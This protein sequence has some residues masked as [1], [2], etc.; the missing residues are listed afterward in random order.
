MLII[1]EDGFA[2]RR[3]LAML[4]LL[5]LP[6]FLFAQWE[7]LPLYG[8]HADRLVQNKFKPNEIYAIIE[9]GGIYRSTDYGETWKMVVTNIDTLGWL[10]P[11]RGIAEFEVSADNI[12]FVNAQRKIWKSTDSGS[13]WSF[14]P[15]LTQGI[16][17]YYTDIEALPDTSILLLHASQRYIIK[18]HTK[19]STYDTLPLTWPT[20]NYV[21]RIFIDPSNTHCIILY[22]INGELVR[23]EDDGKHFKKS[24]FSDNDNQI[25]G[26]Q[27]LGLNSPS[28]YGLWTNHIADTGREYNYFESL[29]SGYS[30]RRRNEIPV[31][32]PKFG[33]PP[34]DRS[35]NDG[36][37]RILMSSENYLTYSDDHGFSFVT[38]ND[39]SVWD[40]NYNSAYWL[41]SMTF[42]C[43]QKSNNGKEWNSYS[44]SRQI[45]G[46]STID[47]DGL[48]GIVFA[49][50][51]DW[52]YNGWNVHELLQS[53][54]SGRNWIPLFRGE[55]ISWVRASAIQENRYY[56]V[57]NSHYLVSGKPGQTSPDTLLQVT[58]DVVQFEVGDAFPSDMF[59]A[60]KSGGRYGYYVSSDF[61]RTWDQWTIPPFRYDV[62]QIIPSRTE[63]G[64]FLVVTQPENPLDIDGMGLWR[65]RGYGLEWRL[66][67][68]TDDLTSTALRLF[69]EDLLFHRDQRVFSSDYGV[70]WYTD[71][72]GIEPGD[73]SDLRGY[74]F[75]SLGKLFFTSSLLWYVHDG[76]AWTKLRD[77]NGNPIRRTMPATLDL[78]GNGLYCGYPYDGLYRIRCSNLTGIE[79]AQMPS[80]SRRIDCYPNPFSTTVTFSVGGERRHAARFLVFDA[81]GRIVFETSVP[82]GSAQVQWNG[83]SSSGGRLPN[84][85]YR[86][87]VFEE[88]RQTGFAHIVHVK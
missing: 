22:G 55:S 23:S 53:D 25:F 5:F 16:S 84:G 56:A 74:S 60:F 27:R 31:I 15:N 28:M 40:I 65:V 13:T 7:R 67:W 33:S 83:Q 20:A 44:G 64:Q 51:G 3:L 47:F 2:M 81:L 76:K 35:S 12:L 6:S 66:T 19:Q 38:E 8:G 18:Y 21:E 70:T 14:D 79:T 11:F 78:V 46:F 73:W 62:F 63:R 10:G 34:N 24:V 43:M 17:T 42:E 29:D 52:S 87:M 86:A 41:G 58:G 82:V 32:L 77:E 54:A 26:V 39:K 9:M 85:N 61:G 88:G 71:T 50:I 80:R 57:L 1:T 59:V 72:T 68:K 30:W 37:D 48:S 69:G 36:A 45:P 75:S 49:E 4:A